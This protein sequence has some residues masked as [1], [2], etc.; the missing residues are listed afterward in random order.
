MKENHKFC[1]PS[2]LRGL[3]KR[4][5]G[6]S[7]ECHMFF[8]PQFH[9]IVSESQAI[10]LNVPGVKGGY[11]EHLDCLDKLVKMMPLSAISNLTI[12]EV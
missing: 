12:K 2:A 4:L 9:D 11:L 5:L 3:M 7:T 1:K 6:W 10:V 8:L